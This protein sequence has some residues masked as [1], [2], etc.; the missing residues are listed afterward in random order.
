MDKDNIEW[1]VVKKPREEGKIEKV[2]VGGKK[3]CVVLWNGKLYATSSRCPHAGADLSLGWCEGEKLVC[4]YHRHRFDLQTGKG[5]EGQGNYI[6]VF[7]LK[8]ENNR[9][10][11]GI[12]K[13][14]W[15]RLGKFF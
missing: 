8:E 13:S 4:S 3:L 5:D 1:F 10:Y 6:D 11:V 15:K 9:W 14:W 7:P 2:E 12:K